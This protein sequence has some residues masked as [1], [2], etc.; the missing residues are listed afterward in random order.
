[1]ASGQWLVASKG[2]D[3]R[4]I[5]PRWN[6]WPMLPL[7]L[8]CAATATPYLFMHVPLIGLMLD[9]GFALVC[10]QRPERSFWIFPGSVAVCARCLGIYL[11][12]TLGLLCRGGTTVAL[13]LLIT[14]TTLN[15]LD[16]ATELVRLHGNWLG[17]RFGLGVALGAGAALLLSSSVQGVSN[18]LS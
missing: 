14:A 13:R 11:G 2:V 15:L 17:V 16:A 18:Q 6:W 10:H 3:S 9:R 12:A 1:V 7:A 5:G 8:A 4:G